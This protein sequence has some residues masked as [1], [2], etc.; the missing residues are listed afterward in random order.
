MGAPDD[1][2]SIRN[3]FTGLYYVVWILT[4][5]GAIALVLSC[6]GV[7]GLMAYAVHGLMKSAFDRSRR[8]PDTSDGAGGEAR[9]VTHGTRAGHRLGQCFRYFQD[10]VRPDL[11]RVSSTDASIF[12]GVSLVLLAVAMAAC[13]A[14]V[15]RALR[16]DPVDA[17]RS[18]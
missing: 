10:F 14:P 18:E 17:L 12:G 9:A 8:R 3:S 1:D 5:T 6:I 7:Y 15:R 11:R 16:V 4:V 2:A 13:Y